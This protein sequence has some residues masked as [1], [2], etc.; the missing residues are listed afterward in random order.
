MSQ[1]KTLGQ[2]AFDAYIESKKGTTFD[3]RPI[4]TWENLGDPVRNAWEAAG[5]AANATNA[6]ELQLGE[7]FTLR[8]LKE[9]HFSQAY[10]EAYNHGTDGHNAKIIIA[11]LSY[12]IAGVELPAHLR[13]PKS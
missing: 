7:Y 8:E 5:E 9:I 10:A 13:Q 12:L 1:Q 6:K 3:G 4:P 11:K 2:I